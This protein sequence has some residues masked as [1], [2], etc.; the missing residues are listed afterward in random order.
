MGIKTILS[1]SFLC[2][3]ACSK[4]KSRSYTQL[5]S[6]TDQRVYIRFSGYEDTELTSAI[7]RAYI[8][9][10]SFTTLANEQ[11]DTIDHKGWGEGYRNVLAQT[12][13]VQQYDYEIILVGP[14]DTFRI[15]RIAMPERND[16][17]YCSG[18][19]AHIRCYPDYCFN[20]LQLNELYLVKNGLPDTPVR[21]NSFAPGSSELLIFRR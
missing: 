3:A 8:N 6:C 15:S 2:L 19:E 20:T 11:T 14:N 10:G 21:A 13:L 9:D 12:E 18:E 7:V 5:I 1:I 4:N 17:S 16:T